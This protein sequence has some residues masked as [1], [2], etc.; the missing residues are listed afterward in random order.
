VALELHLPAN[1]NGN[2]NVMRLLAGAILWIHL[3]TAADHTGIVRC[4]GEPVAGAVVVARNSAAEVTATTDES[5]LYVLRGLS[6]GKWEITV[7]LFGFRTA[8]QTVVVEAGGEPLEWRLAVESPLDQADE[9]QALKAREPKERSALPAEDL[10]GLAV[11]AAGAEEALMVSGSLSRGLELASR[12]DELTKMRAE[13]AKDEAKGPPLPGAPKAE[14]PVAGVSG[15]FE[16]PGDFTG[17]GG[18][19]PGGGI[20]K[21]K[22]PK[23][24][25]EKGKPEVPGVAIFGNRVNRWRDKA[26]GSFS[27]SLRHSSLDARPYSASGQEVEKA[28][29]S[30]TRAG[31]SLGGPLAIPGL[32]DTSRTFF[33]VSLAVVRS[34]NPFHGVG[35]TPTVLERAG[36]FGTPGLQRG[37]IFD[38]AASLPF[39]GNRIPASRLARISVGLLDYIPL[40]N[41]SGEA[42][43]YQLMVS[44]PQRSEDLTV[45]VNHSISGAAHLDVSLATQWRSSSPAQLF[46]FRDLTEGLGFSAGVSWLHSLGGKSVNNLRVSFSRNR[47]L[48]TPFFAFQR[49]VAGELGI[50]GVSRDPVNYGPPNLRFTNYAP[51]SDASAQ[52]RR[53]RS[54]AL[55]NSLKW[56]Q[57]EHKVDAGVELRRVHTATVTDQ[58]ARGTLV[59]SGLATSRLDAAGHPAA[60]TG[61]DLADF[62]LGLPQS[63]SI[64]WGSSDTYFRGWAVSG[65]L[66]DDW[67]PLPGFTLKYGLRYEYF[68]PPSERYG[69][70]TNLDVAPGFTAAAPV[71]AGGEG[72]FSGRFPAGLVEGDRNNLSPRIGLAWR[73]IEGSKFHIRSGYGVFFDGSI[74]Q[75]FP[76]LLAS[77]PPFAKANAVSTS[78]ERPLWIGTAFTQTQVKAVTNT[79][80]VDRH[81]RSGYAQTWNLSLKHDLAR[82]IGLEV[83]YVGTKG[84]RLNVQRL[85]N[86][87]APGSPLT[88]EQ[89][90]LI[91]NAVGFTWESS[92]GNSIFHAGQVKLIRHFQRGVAAEMLYTFS[93]AIDNAASFG[94]SGGT[95]AQ[96]DRNLRA[97]R[98]L[99]NFD[100]RHRLGI[101][102]LWAS[103]FGD[104][105]TLLRGGGL[106]PALLGN[107]TAGG[108]VIW[109]SGT[110]FTAR[111]LGNRTDA[112][113][114]G[115]IGAGRADASGAEIKSR[116]GYFNTLAFTIPPAGRFGNAARNTIPG[117]FS[118]AVNLAVA[119]SFRLGEQRKRLEARAECSNC[120][121]HVNVNSL[122]TVVNS[123]EY[124]LALGAQ[125]MRSMVFHL[126][127]SF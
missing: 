20:P 29:Y 99:A 44:T 49:D 77:Q 97:E 115:A 10:A 56:H 116:T 83:G 46:G 109:A 73:P 106:K 81:Y 35:T 127:L 123:S 24:A 112:G 124:G 34:R 80:G 120:T 91:G 27:A 6:P 122:G 33:F 90:R 110:P 65:W 47:T 85:P 102:F 108:A 11:E 42:R 15:R 67:K 111:V 101:S 100:Q 72:P 119:R 54:L 93:K 8:T 61:W 68:A 28:R 64:R 21:P 87:A 48:L 78:L 82:H 94:G 12:D 66:Q 57:E 22:P 84:T 89:R 4:G 39:P 69:R 45:R 52:L 105:G 55:S 43:N 23:G 30:T 17:F 86:R 114:T 37:V 2:G 50:E 5:G 125:P 76:P 96:D 40:P 3:A 62:L 26:R 60:N 70:M 71:T 75:R 103:P 126:R 19:G 59:F 98:G 36:D 32:A 79:A 104:S 51:L 41:Q 25:K 7:R 53:D 74:Y 107:W 16:A 9:K 38:P 113:G 1:R 58:D 13:W 31:V 63:G 88:S 95:P 92:E 18:P 118:A 14:K 121:N 117:P